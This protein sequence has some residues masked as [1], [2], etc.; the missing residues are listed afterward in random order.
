[1][2]RTQSC[3]SCLHRS[4]RHNRCDGH[5]CRK[6]P[7]DKWCTR[8]ALQGQSSL[9]RTALSHHQHRRYRPHM[10]CTQCWLCPPSTSQLHRWG[11][12][13]AWKHPG[14]WTQHMAFAHP[15]DTCIQARSFH[16]C[17]CLR[18]VDA[19]RLRTPSLH[20][21]CMTWLRGMSCTSSWMARLGMSRW[22]IAQ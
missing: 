15:K 12:R 3:P 11:T 17:S 16:T 9:L 4:S 6:S 22:G 5:Q 2:S 19:C 18:Q 8:T 14:M 13:F 1:M 10:S 7:R 20:Q 21:H